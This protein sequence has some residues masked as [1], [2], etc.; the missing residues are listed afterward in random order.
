MIEARDV[1]RMYLTRIERDAAGAPVKLYLFTRARQANEPKGV[2]IDPYVSFGLPVLVETG[3]PT[4]VSADRYKSGESIQALSE[5]YERPPRDIEEAI[6]C[7]LNR[8]AA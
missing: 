3:I 6:R 7:D 2:V 4:A 1:L 8:Q 5:D